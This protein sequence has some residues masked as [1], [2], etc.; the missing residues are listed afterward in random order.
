[1]RSETAESAVIAQEL[2]GEGINFLIVPCDVDPAVAAGQ[3]AA[4]AGIPAMSSC[5]STPTLPG[6]VGE[7]MFSNYTADN[8]QAAALA[9]YAIKQGYKN[10]F[11]M[12]SKDTPYTQKLPEYFAARLPEEGR[13]DR[14]H[15]RIQDG[16]AGFRRRSNQT[17]GIVAGAGCHHDVG[18]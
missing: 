9:D 3:I 10:A 11:V 4:A 16:S 7:Y 17:Q 15:C 14:R 2:V 18:L 12:L 13:D 6:I 8:L 5:A 1:M